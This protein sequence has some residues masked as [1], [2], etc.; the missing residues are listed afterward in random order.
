MGPEA[1]HRMLERNP[2][3][4]RFGRQ[5]KLGDLEAHELVM[6][7]NQAKMVVEAAKRHAD[8][9]NNTSDDHPI[10]DVNPEILVKSPDVLTEK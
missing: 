6:L 4:E 9:K 10:P 3:E 7:E 5:R 1:Y 2:Y 8:S